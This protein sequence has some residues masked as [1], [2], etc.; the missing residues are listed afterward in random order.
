[1]KHLT[2]GDNIWATPVI[3]HGKLYIKGVTELLCFDISAGTA[4]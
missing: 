2:E 1:M 3:Y 4:N